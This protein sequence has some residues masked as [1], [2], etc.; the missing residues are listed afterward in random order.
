MI[1][2]SPEVISDITESAQKVRFLKD[3]Q[4]QIVMGFCKDSAFLLQRWPDRRPT[5]NFIGHRF[6]G[7]LSSAT[8][9]TIAN[10]GFENFAVLLTSGKRHTLNEKPVL[11]FE[12]EEPQGESG[13]CIILYGVPDSQKLHVRC[14]TKRASVELSESF[15][16]KNPVD[17]WMAKDITEPVLISHGLKINWTKLTEEI[18]AVRCR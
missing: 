7:T 8:R 14:L 16:I 4:I 9:V 2:A 10:R 11:I 12:T 3:D 18:F 1:F 13:G 15:K 5:I 17:L 6:S